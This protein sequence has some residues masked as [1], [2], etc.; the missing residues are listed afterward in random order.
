MEVGNRIDVQMR[1]ERI[2]KVLE[3]LLVVLRGKSFVYKKGRSVITNNKFN[4]RNQVC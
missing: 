1:L 4:L 3:N 2:Q